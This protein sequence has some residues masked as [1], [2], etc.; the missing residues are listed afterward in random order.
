MSRKPRSDD[1]VVRSDA[2]DRFEKAVDVVLKSPPRHREKKSKQ[3]A[4]KGPAKSRSR[5]RLPAPRGR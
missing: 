3:P 5:V 2:W 1:E 4:K